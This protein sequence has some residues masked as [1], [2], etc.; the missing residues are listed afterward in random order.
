MI[1]SIRGR[2]DRLRADLDAHSC[3]G[4]RGSNG[5]ERHIKHPLPHFVLDELRGKGDDFGWS[6]DASTSSIGLCSC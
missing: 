1:L 5:L 4:L 2:H 3:L 6:E